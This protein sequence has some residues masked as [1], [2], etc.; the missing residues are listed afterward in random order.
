MHASE[1]HHAFAAAQE[2]PYVRHA[3]QTLRKAIVY[4]G[5]DHPVVASA[6]SSLAALL[7]GG[8]A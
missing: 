7:N 6:E 2:T 4:Y 1:H 8:H 5:W 3:R